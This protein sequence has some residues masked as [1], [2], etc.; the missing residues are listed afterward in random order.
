[1][2]R[3]A[4]VIILLCACWV[5]PVAGASP[6]APAAAPALPDRF[7]IPAKLKSD[8]KLDKAKDGDD[9]TLEVNK[10]V[11]GPAGNVL[12]PKKARLLGKVT[13]VDGASLALHIERAEW[14]GGSLPLN[15]YIAG[16]VTVTVPVGTASNVHRTFNPNDPNG[17]LTPPE[18]SDP[19]KAGAGLSTN[20]NTGGL[21]GNSGDLI[22]DPQAERRVLA[23]SADERF[24]SRIGLQAGQEKVSA[25]T[26]FLLRH[27]D[28]DYNLHLL[29]VDAPA[30]RG[31]V[32]QEREKATKGAAASQFTLGSM[33]LQG[34]VLR[35]D[36]AK[37]AAW[38]LKAADQGVPEAQTDMG[39]LYAQGD[40]VAQEDVAS[41]MW[42]Q[43][44]VDAGQ[45]QGR[46]AL[47]MLEGRM[48][49][50]K[51]ADAK[52]RADVWKQAHP[53]KPG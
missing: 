24:G 39:V 33:Y 13:H 15:A 29:L 40:G 4:I 27:L 49:P 23:V 37:A 35:S 21:V 20:S 16:P 6:Q 2:K 8:L 17:S 25:G 50:D 45:V 52:H 19:R 28:P 30:A 14:E 22:G 31:A 1:M 18:E 44:A 42:F 26:V 41:Y 12:I 9:V 38:L 3:V 43:L 46:R 34:G 32:Q 48:S 10:D 53:K 7:D 36:R 11:P 47:T 51:V 5:T